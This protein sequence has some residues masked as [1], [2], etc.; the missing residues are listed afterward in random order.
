MSDPAIQ[1]G[2]FLFNVYRG[3]VVGFLASVCSN[4]KVIAVR[5]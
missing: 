3:P 5:R 1:I 4:I 2:L